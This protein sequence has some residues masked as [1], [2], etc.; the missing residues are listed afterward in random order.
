MLGHGSVLSW[1]R[2]THTIP[3]T[4]WHAHEWL[5]GE[6]LALLHAVWGW[7][8]VVIFSSAMIGLTIGIPAWGM[9]KYLRNFYVVVIS[10]MVLVALNQHILA[11]PHVLVLPVLMLWVVQ[12]VFTRNACKAHSFFVVLLMIPWANIHGSFPSGWTSRACGLGRISLT[13]NITPVVSL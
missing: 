6:M 12:L 13:S 9:S 5:S 2:F 3:G 1:D 8:G 7:K 10:A 4:D 11:R